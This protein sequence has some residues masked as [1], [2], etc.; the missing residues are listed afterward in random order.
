MNMSHLNNLVE[1]ICLNMLKLSCDYS[2]CKQKLLF[3]HLTDH[4]DY[5]SLLKFKY[6][7]NLGIN[8]KR[9]EISAF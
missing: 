6:F 9:M 7:K 4:V 1:Q 3:L 5:K 8:F 2:K